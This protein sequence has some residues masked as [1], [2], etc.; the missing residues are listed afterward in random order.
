MFGLMVKEW[1]LFPTHPRLKSAAAKGGNDGVLK[2]ERENI[3][4]W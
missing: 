1:S 3:L 2:K 4:K